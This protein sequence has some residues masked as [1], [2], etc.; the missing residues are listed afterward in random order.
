MFFNQDRALIGDLCSDVEHQTAA[1]E[2]SSIQYQYTRSFPAIPGQFCKVS[3][4]SL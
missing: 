4:F 2:K 3:S 1:I